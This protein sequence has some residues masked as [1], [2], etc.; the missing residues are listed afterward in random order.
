MIDEG[1]GMEWWKNFKDVLGDAD[2][3]P[4]RPTAAQV[5]ILA[6]QIHDTMQWATEMTMKPRKLYH[7]KGAPWWNTDCAEVVLDLQAAEAEEDR[8]RHAARLRAATHKA[9]RT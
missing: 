1:K 3:L 5:D 4:I 7:L 9:K 6:K 2:P 8:K